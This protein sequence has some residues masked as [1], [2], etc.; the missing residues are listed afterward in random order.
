MQDV[1][2]D[3]QIRDPHYTLKARTLLPMPPTENAELYSHWD[4]VVTTSKNPKKLINNPNAKD[5]R[6]FRV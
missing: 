2:R 1:S 4:K 3:S 6:V 5:V